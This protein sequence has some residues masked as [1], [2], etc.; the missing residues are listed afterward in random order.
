M[1]V[2][3]CVC[4]ELNSREMLITKQTVK[5]KGLKKLYKLI[6]PFNEIS[7]FL[8]ICVCV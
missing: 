3:V 1:Y 4:Y 2:C 6:F 5:F 8:F 7:L